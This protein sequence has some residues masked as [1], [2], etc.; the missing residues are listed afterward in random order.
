MWRQ[1]GQHK[2]PDQNAIKMI[3]TDIPILNIS[4]K[5]PKSSVP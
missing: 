4:S 2:I 5:N 1:R 3:N